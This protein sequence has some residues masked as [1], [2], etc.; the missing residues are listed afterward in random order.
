MLKIALGLLCA[1]LVSGCIS[2]YVDS[3]SSSPP[4]DPTIAALAALIAAEMAASPS[5]A[6]DSY[7]GMEY[8]AWIPQAPP[9]SDTT[10]SELA[11]VPFSL[12]P[13]PNDGD[14]APVPTYMPNMALFDFSLSR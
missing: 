6:V 3:D 13:Q 5:G 10:P 1:G 9:P 4:P 8:P 11:P 14:L 2:P 12:Q 7:G